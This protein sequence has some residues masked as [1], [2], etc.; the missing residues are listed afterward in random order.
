MPRELEG[1]VGPGHKVNLLEE[2]KSERVRLLY[3][4]NKMTDIAPKVCGFVISAH[5]A[6]GQEV[7]EEGFINQLDSYYLKQY[8]IEHLID[9]LA[10]ERLNRFD[11]LL[12][13]QT[14]IQR[15]GRASIIDTLFNV[16]QT[17]KIDDKSIVF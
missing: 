7:R 2:Y 1:G 11:N 12:T 10:R 14:Q 4:M 8:A 3:Q 16:A 9:L 13:K 5:E 17:I 15:L 6:Q